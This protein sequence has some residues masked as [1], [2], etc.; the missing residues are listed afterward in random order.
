MNSE[1]EWFSFDV[2]IVSI[3]AKHDILTDLLEKEG[4]T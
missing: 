1:C 2:E 3:S 4:D